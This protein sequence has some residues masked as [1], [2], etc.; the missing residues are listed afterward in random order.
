MDTFL[1]PVCVGCE[2]KIH[3]IKATSL[4]DAKSRIMDYYMETCD[5]AVDSSW[6]EF[7]ESMSVNYTTE[8]GEPTDIYYYTDY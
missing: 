5:D 4:S 3:T 2:N 6:E 8:I 1:Y 7:V